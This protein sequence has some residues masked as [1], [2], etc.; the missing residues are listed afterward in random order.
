MCD[1][2]RSTPAPTP[3]VS[4]KIGAVLLAAGAG[5]RLGGRAKSL[6]ELDGVPLIRRLIAALMDKGIHPIIVVLGHHGDAIEKVLHDLPVTRVR[7]PSP[8]DGQSTSLRMGLHAI[9]ADENVNMDGVIVAL[10]DQPLIGTIEIAGLVEAFKAR[11]ERPMVVPRVAGEPGNPVVI[12]AALRER[13]LAGDAHATGQRWRKAN[14]SHIAWFDT[15]NQHYRI[16]IDTLEDI[17]RFNERSGQ[18]LRWPAA[19]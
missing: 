1:S 13:W 9:D 2:S 3:S 15:D 16:D 19:K 6:L 4:L 8:D 10:A 14:Q 7:N 5:S 12:T 11:G 17:A 18:V